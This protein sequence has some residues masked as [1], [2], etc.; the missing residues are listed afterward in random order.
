MF[1]NLTNNLRNY[2]LSNINANKAETANNEV[3]KEPSA[4]ESLLKKNESDTFVFSQRVEIETKPQEKLLYAVPT[5]KDPEIIEPTK[6]VVMYGVPEPKPEPEEPEKPEDPTKIV[7]MYGIPEPK[8][9]PIEP[10]K[11]VVMYGVPEPK[12]EPVPTPKPK[13]PA[14]QLFQRISENI[15]NL[16]KKIFGNIFNR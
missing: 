15:N 8:P 13:T 4:E 6:I 12:P 1:N 7:V 11:I 16:F 5:P 10:T 3:A 9:E 2:F 14:E